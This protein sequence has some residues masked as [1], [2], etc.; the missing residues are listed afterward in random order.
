MKKLIVTLLF[1]VWH[2][3]I[4]ASLGNCIWYNAKFELKSGKAVEGYFCFPSWDLVKFKFTEKEFNMFIENYL[5]SRDTLRL[6]LKFQALKY[7]QAKYVE[8]GQTKLKAVVAEDI[9]KLCKKDIITSH[10]LGFLKNDN[11]YINYKSTKSYW[12]DP[13]II[14]ELNQQEIDSL[15]YKPFATYKITEIIENEDYY[16]LSY[17]KAIKEKELLAYKKRFIA[18]KKI[19]DN[20]NDKKSYISFIREYAEIKQELRNKNIV[21]FGLVWIN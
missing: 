15:Q 6:I 11:E 13:R 2:L 10:Y 20:C 9:V 19:H 17:N 7:P 12:D 5:K 3:S 4:Y 1:V 21:L 8:D 14:D 16:L 18:L